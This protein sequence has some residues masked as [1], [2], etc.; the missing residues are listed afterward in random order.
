M[1]LKIK[2]LSYYLP[3]IIQLFLPKYGRIIT[4]RSCYCDGN[5]NLHIIDYNEG[6][7]DLSRQDLKLIL[8]PISDLTKEIEVNGEKFVP[9]FKI[10]EIE[11]KGTHHVENIRDMYFS[12]SPTL[13]CSSHVGTASRSSINMR[14]L[15]LNN[16]W[17]IEKLL[18][19]HFDIYG[20]IDNGLAVDINNVK[21]F[22]FT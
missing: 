8:H 15:L 16:Y 1:K 5:G 13:L 3:S 2:H 19:W 4:M 21:F 10:F 12:K 18:E 17:K 22:V 11:Y 7:Y 6:D 14:N 20:L 9:I